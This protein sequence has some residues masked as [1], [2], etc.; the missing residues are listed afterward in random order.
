MSYSETL[1]FISI[2]TAGKIIT[3]YVS[4]C[5]FPNQYIKIMMQVAYV[6]LN[7][8]LAVKKQHSTRR[9]LFLPENLT[10]I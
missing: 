1:V 4:I 6:K 5:K 7:P 9:T 3:L 10:E 2:P 8:I